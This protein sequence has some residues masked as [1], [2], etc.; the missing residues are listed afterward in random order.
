MPRDILT[1][2]EI[3]LHVNRASGKCLPPVYVQHV[4]FSWF[5]QSNTYEFQ[6][7]DDMSLGIVLILKKIWNKMSVFEPKF[8]QLREAR[9]IPGSPQV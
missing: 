8:R 5:K 2:R 6:I 4:P 9:W 3:L 1:A 7:I